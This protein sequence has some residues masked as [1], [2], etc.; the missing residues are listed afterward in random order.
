ML[1]ITDADVNVAAAAQPLIRNGIMLLP[2]RG[3]MVTSERVYR[4][5]DEGAA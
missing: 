3:V 1:D 2:K 4:L 5:L